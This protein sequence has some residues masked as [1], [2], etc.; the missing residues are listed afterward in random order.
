MAFFPFD[1]LVTEMVRLF[2]V[3]VIRSKGPDTRYIAL[4]P[5]MASSSLAQEEGCKSSINLMP[6]ET[7]PALTEEQ[8]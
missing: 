7:K 8:T 4:S 2:A 1:T 6:V 3:E 5:T